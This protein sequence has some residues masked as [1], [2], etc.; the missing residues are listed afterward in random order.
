[1]SVLDSAAHNQ[2]QLKITWTVKSFILDLCTNVYN[3]SQPRAVPSRVENMTDTVR[4]VRVV[5]AIV[6]TTSAFCSSVTE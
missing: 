1:M 5:F 6:K 3:F 2:L 4:S